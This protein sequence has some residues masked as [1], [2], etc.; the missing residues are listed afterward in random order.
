VKLE[1]LRDVSIE[2][3]LAPWQSGVEVFISA[4]DL[5]RSKRYV[6]RELEFDELEPGLT[7]A[8]LFE[9][10]MKDAQHLMDSLWFCGLRPSEGTGSAGSLEA[11]QSHLE[12]MRKIAF[13]FLEVEENATAE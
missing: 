5:P 11:T 10:S 3:Q 6:V 13:H 2:V 9:L 4:L 8:P 1:N 7:C 12:D